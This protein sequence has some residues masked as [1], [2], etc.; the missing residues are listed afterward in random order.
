MFLQAYNK[1]IEVIKNKPMTL[2]GLSL[3][4]G[5]LCFLAILLCLPLGIVASAFCLLLE[6]GM[7]KVYLDGLDG[8][9]G[10]LQRADVTQPGSV[11]RET[12]EPDSQT[13]H[14]ELIIREPLYSRRVADM[15]EYRG[16]SDS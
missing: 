7:A 16:A 4:N 13:A 15:L 9:N 10:R 8:K 6:A 14:I 5:F 1:A 11:E 12:V 2:W 3:M